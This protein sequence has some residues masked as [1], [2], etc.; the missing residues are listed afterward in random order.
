MPSLEE[1][2]LDSEIKATVLQGTMS[3]RRHCMILVKDFE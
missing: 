3:S 1:A 2:G